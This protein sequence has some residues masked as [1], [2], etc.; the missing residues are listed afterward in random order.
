[1][2]HAFALSTH[3]RA[4]TRRTASRRF[5]VDVP[6]VTIEDGRKA[7]RIAEFYRGRLAAQETTYEIAYS[8]NDND[9]IRNDSF[10]DEPIEIT[11][12]VDDLIIN[13]SSF[14]FC[15]PAREEE[16]TDGHGWA[17]GRTGN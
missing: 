3:A 4:R 1:M 17:D 9:Q 7:D 8:P 16:M 12:S 6:R 2:K 10:G 14:R 15:S 11:R 5:A 13:L